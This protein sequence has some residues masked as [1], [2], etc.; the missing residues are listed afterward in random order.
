M[1]IEE[2]DFELPEEA[3]AQE[4]VAPR[5][6]CRLMYLPTSGPTAHTIFSE[7]P[8]LL[9]PDDL[10][11][12]ND[13]KVLPA[14]VLAR[15]NSGAEVEFL[16]L[17][18]AGYS[19]AGAEER[20]EAL[21]RPSKRL[22]SGEVL[23]VDRRP[24][25]GLR[26]YLGDGRWVVESVGGTTVVDI[27]EDYGRLPLPPYIKE[28][29][30]DHGVYQTVYGRVPGSAAAPTA[31]LHFTDGLLSLLKEAGVRSVGVTL[32]VGLDTFLPIRESVVEEHPIHRE[33]YEVSQEALQIIRSTRSKGGR[34]IAVGTTSVRVLE[35]L[36]R[37]GTLTQDGLEHD[38]DSDIVE[39]S[40]DIFITP[41]HGFLAVDALLTNLHLP[42]SSVLALTMAF[43]G[44]ERIR[45]AYVD[46][47]E[48]GYRFF[49][50]GDAMLVERPREGT[51]WV[52]ES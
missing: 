1:R 47:V 30:V 21:V 38:G 39:G 24:C 50:F 28:Y 7:L 35:T 34:V 25:L 15:R 45:K 33:R 6:A 22:K 32:H 43:G 49:S 37:D 8:H 16:F 17:H 14:R 23:L 44:V 2:L 46:A 41:G 4:P 51:G 11:V 48:K 36:A 10:L 9:R 12:F 31:G 20:W 13:S 5:D 3:I 40:T 19:R 26:E 18:R 52:D 29:P 27:M 42:R